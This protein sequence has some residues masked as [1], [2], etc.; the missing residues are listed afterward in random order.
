MKLKEY[1][2]ITV[3][4]ALY[5]VLSITLGT[6][7]YGAIQ[8]RYAEVLNVLALKD[9]RFI[10]SLTLGCFLTNIIGIITGANPLGMMDAFVGTL[11]T[12]IAG[13]LMYHFRDVKTA[14]LP[15]VSLLMPALINGVLIGAE[16]AYV[17]MPDELLK[18][19]IIN[20]FGVFI[21]EVIIVLLFG[22]LIM[23]P[24]FKQLEKIKL[25]SY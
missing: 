18:G 8:F 3:V 20:F 5:T 25:K 10:W 14:N 7:A 13:Y 17:F 21:S 11:A 9:K 15:I 12:L 16:L 19:F 2:Y 1:T 6:F 23:K 4:A 24:L 22:L